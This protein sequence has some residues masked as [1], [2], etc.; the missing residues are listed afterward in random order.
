M[1]MVDIMRVNGKMIRQQV[2]VYIDGV[3]AVN[4]RVN[5]K[6]VK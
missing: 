2:K 1:Q 6:I 3:M 5:G 4:M